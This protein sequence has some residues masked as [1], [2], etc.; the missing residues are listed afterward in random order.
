MMLGPGMSQTAEPP[1][2]AE[3][4]VADDG[5]AAGPVPRAA[6]DPPRLPRPILVRPAAGN[7]GHPP[8]F[9]FGGAIAAPDAFAAVVNELRPGPTIYVCCFP[10]NGGPADGNW[11][12]RSLP[13]LAGEVVEEIR[14]IQP[15]GPY[16]LC[17][18]SLGARIVFEAGRQIRLARE[19]VGL[20][21][22]LDGWAPGYPV[23]YSARR[24]ALIHLRN[25]LRGRGALGYLK[26]R[27]AN[28]RNRLTRRAARKTALMN[29]VK[30]DSSPSSEPLT[31]L[32][33]I[34]A[35]HHRPAVY[36]GDI[37][38]V[39]ADVTPD[40][41]G[42]CFNDVTNGWTPFVRGSIDVRH[43]RCR[44]LELLSPPA[45]A[46]VAEVLDNCMARAL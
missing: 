25:L 22:L 14:R 38:L 18:Y 7:N 28:V 15:N 41:P 31:G 45:A 36:E 17:G 1:V 6:A 44:H 4:D 30:L 3:G 16:L 34:A 13:S 42:S 24:R 5:V 46:Q 29:T 20:L 9:Y 35:L 2:A 40:W 37:V 10:G 26:G 11:A 12:H 43:V 21:A 23:R 8:L 27:F 19:P 39:R 33:L 32:G